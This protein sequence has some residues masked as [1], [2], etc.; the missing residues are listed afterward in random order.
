MKETKKVV[1]R[2]NI[3]E[4]YQLKEG[5][6]KFAFSKRG[7]PEVHAHCAI[8]L[9]FSGDPIAIDRADRVQLEKELGQFCA[10][11]KFGKI[12]K[13]AVDNVFDEFKQA[14]LKKLRQVSGAMAEYD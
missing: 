6:V 8:T 2:P 14:Y 5:E 4:S 1:K 9:V 12:T 11:M 7:K 3:M 10:R 13:N